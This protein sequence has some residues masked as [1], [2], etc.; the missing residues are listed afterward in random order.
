MSGAFSLSVDVSVR[1]VPTKSKDA[2]LIDTV[3]LLFYIDDI[4][5]SLS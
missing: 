3:V 4:C 2:P 5:A 1:S